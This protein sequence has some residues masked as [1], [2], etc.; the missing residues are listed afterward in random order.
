MKKLISILL[1]LGLLITAGI[2]ASAVTVPEA[3]SPVLVVCIEP[4]HNEGL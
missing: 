1:I 4:P 3:D 2:Y